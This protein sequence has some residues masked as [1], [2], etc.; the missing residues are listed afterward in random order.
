MV[1]APIYGILGAAMALLA[2]AAIRLTTTLISFPAILGSPVPRLW[3]NL[4]DLRL[5]LHAQ[6]LRGSPSGHY[7]A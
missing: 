6:S 2:A 7:R 1:L 4:S 3:L 5:L